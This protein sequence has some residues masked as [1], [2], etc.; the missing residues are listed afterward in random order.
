VKSGKAVAGGAA[1]N[2][3]PSSDRK[4][5]EG[6]TTRG[7]PYRRVETKCTWCGTFISKPAAQALRPRNVFCGRSC[8]GKHMMYQRL[9][10]SNASTSALPER[11]DIV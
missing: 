2:P 1:G 6:V 8:A 10:G 9:H 4:V 5:I 7:R 11:D 3:E